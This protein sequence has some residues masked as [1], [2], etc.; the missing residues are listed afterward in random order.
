MNK[1]IADDFWKLKHQIDDEVKRLGW[2][3]EECKD[4]IQKHYGKRSR[5]VMTDAQLKHMLCQLWY[6]GHDDK[7]EVT[8][9]KVNRRK[10]RRRT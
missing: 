10:R 7:S 6:L 4:Y 2:S 9:S 8:K 3:I 5:L 1:P